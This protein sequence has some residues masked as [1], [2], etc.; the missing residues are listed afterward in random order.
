MDHLI[1]IAKAMA[2]LSTV[3]VAI[4]LCIFLHQLTS[5]TIELEATTKAASATIQTLP[6]QVDARLAS[7]QT[8][9]LRKVDTVQNKLTA[10]VNVLADKSDAR[11]AS[12]QSDLVSTLNTQL[13]ETNKNF[14]AQLSETNKSI[15]LLATTYAGVPTQIAA[16]YN[17]DFDPFFNCKVNALCLQ[18]QA[19]DTLF[20][21]RASSRDTSTTLMNLQATLPVLESN[22][23]KISD[24][25]AV[26]MPK[27]TANVNQITA[28]IQK[29]THPHWYDRLVTYL[30]DAALVFHAFP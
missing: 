12:I 28:N 2:L 6:S 22:T 18:G 14:N 4:F 17:K 26:E 1:K 25:F 7:I 5:T 16:Q 9:V 13:A 11:L 24:T 10:Q 8:D 19:S 23:V 20:A 3:P 30:V 21:L 15:N 29:M 27:I